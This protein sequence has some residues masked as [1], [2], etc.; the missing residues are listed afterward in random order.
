MTYENYVFD[1]YGTLIDIHT[2]ESGE[3]FWRSIAELYA[4]AGVRYSPKELQK[5]YLLYCADDERTLALRT[6]YAFPEIRLENVFLRLL[7][8][9]NIPE[10]KKTEWVRALA[11]CF[12]TLSR[13]HLC[14]FPP[15]LPTLRELKRRGKRLFLLSNAQTVFTEDELALTGVDGFFDGILIS[16][17]CGM[18]KP[19]SE[20]MRLLL[21]RFGLDPKKTVMI[22]N[23]ASTDMVIASECGVD[24]VLLNTSHEC[25]E[26]L[27]KRIQGLGLTGIRIISS[28]DL[29]ELI[30]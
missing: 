12:R 22:G 2:D 23:D 29:S 14:V 25:A 21:D 24:G 28:G 7:D 5:K 27:N 18:R 10:E 13:D 8:G 11:K 26:T 16:S 9:E 17:D 19:Q 20:F 30:K 3:E 6:G 1:L 15:T 4:C